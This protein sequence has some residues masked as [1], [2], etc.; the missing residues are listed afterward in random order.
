MLQAT[1]VRAMHPIANKQQSSGHKADTQH[2]NQGSPATSHRPP[3]CFAELS[4]SRLNLP[5]PHAQPWHLVL[6]GMTPRGG[7]IC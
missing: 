1:D 5:N 6:A 7:L 4:G 2:T 3:L